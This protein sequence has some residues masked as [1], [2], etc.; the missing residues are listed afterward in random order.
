MFHKNINSESYEKLSNDIFCSRIVFCSTPW[1]S[2]PLR[3]HYGSIIEPHR[4][5]E[6]ATTGRVVK[7]STVE[8]G[9]LVLRYVGH[10]SMW[11]SFSW[12][13]A[14]HLLRC[15]GP[16]HVGHLTIWD[17]WDGPVECPAYPGSTV[18]G[19]TVRGKSTL[20]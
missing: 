3:I 16:G 14:K 11:D 8:P 20:L 9:Y 18:T 1:R 13:T 7:T 6:K 19:T 5:L 15:T 4:E 2:V 17:S 12:Y 10:L